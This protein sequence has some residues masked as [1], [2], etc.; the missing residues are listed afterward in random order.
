MFSLSDSR[1][2]IDPDIDPDDDPDE[3]DEEEDEDGEDEDDD[4]DGENGEK[5][6]VLPRRSC[7]PRPARCLTS[8]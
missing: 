4:E 5:W 1:R 3:P 8:V 2:A 6:Y 7:T